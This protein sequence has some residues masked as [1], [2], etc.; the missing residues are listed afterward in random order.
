VPWTLGCAS[1]AHM[2]A[3]QLEFELAFGLVAAVGQALEELLHP[4]DVE[5]AMQGVFATALEISSRK[6]LKPM[7]EIFR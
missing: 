3:Q 4:E 7:E 5:A 1:L 2:N 6:N